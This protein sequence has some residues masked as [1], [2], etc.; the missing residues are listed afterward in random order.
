[1][2]KKKIRDIKE[3]EKRKEQAAFKQLMMV[4]PNPKVK[5]WDINDLST[6]L[7]LQHRGEKCELL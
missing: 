3:Q 1:M 5:V 7:A 4:A 2:E 6:Y